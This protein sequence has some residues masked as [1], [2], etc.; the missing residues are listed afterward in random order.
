MAQLSRNVIELT[1]SIEGSFYPSTQSE[2]LRDVILKGPFE[3][4]GGI[5][6]RNIKNVGG[7]TVTGPVLATAEITLT[8]PQSANR[9]SVLRFLSGI[10]A[11]LTIAM[12]E[13]GLKIEETVVSDINKAS[14]IVKGDVVSDMVKIENSLIFGNLRARQ[15]SVV[16]SV[17]VGSILTEEDLRIENSLFVSFSGGRVKLF[18]KNGC[19]LPYGT[20]LEPIIFEETQFQNGE[21]KGAELRYIALCRTQQLGCRFTL[22]GISCLPFYSNKCDFKNVRIGSADIRPHKTDNGQ[23]LY[24]LN[25]AQRALDLTPIEK[26]IKLV[27]SYLK[28]LL[29]YEH[30]DK[31]SQEHAREKWLNMFSEEEKV[32]LERAL[33]IV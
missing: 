11:S 8:H 21:K 6:A 27:E 2:I 4:N 3:I 25:L 33:Q 15:A 20:A 23:M 31:S 30:L 16:N 14:I 17:I 26:E 24:A 22:G 13:T 7:G 28:E 32:L 10:N 1:L 9:N 12:E 19:W 29:I 18:G 5:F